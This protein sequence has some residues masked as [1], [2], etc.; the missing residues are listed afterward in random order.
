MINIDDNAKKNN[1]IFES[2]KRKEN[3]EHDGKEYYCFAV[4]S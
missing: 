3:R 1:L 4:L 2:K